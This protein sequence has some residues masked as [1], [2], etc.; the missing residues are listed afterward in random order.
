MSVRESLRLDALVLASRP[1]APSEEEALEVLSRQVLDSGLEALPWT[2]EAGSLAAR[3]SLCA[4]RLGPPWPVLS[5]EELLARA[6]EWLPPA[7]KGLRGLAELSPSRLARALSALV[8]GRLLPRLDEL[9]PPA[10]VS[11]A[12][13][14]H[15]IVY[16]EGAPYAQCKLQECFGLSSSPLLGCGEPLTL[17]LLSPGGA[18]L[19][20]TRDLAYFWKE[21][22]P[23]ARAQMRGRYPRH[24]WPEDPMAFEPTALSK[25]ALERRK[26]RS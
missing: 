19:A 12:G 16:G 2:G 14:V 13:T 20:V 25:K 23:Q 3:V 7:L 26:G 10:W 15:R 22:Y 11:P 9:A 8:P 4:Q 5:R 21:A 1:A 18:P 6:P 24:P 17:R